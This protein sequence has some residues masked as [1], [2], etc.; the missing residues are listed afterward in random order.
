MLLLFH[1]RLYQNICELGEKMLLTDNIAEIKN[2]GEKRAKLLNSLGIYTIADLI[3]YF[4]RDYDDRSNVKSIKDVEEEQVNTIK[5]FVVSKPETLFKKNISI[6]KTRVD[7]GT[8][9]IECVWYNQPYIKNNLKP[10]SQYVFTGKVVC[11]YNR[12]QIESP[13]YELFDDSA[14]LSNG[15]I[16]PI[17]ASKAK[18]SQ[19]LL[20][21][22]IYDTLEQCRQQLIDFIPKAILRQYNLCDRAFAVENIHFPKDNESFFCAR[23]RLV[24][25]ELFL[26]QL[27]L[28][29][30]KG[31]VKAKKSSVV[32]KNLSTAPIES[33]IS[34]E[35]TSAQKRVLEEIKGDMHS[36]CVMNRLIQGDVGS[37]KTAVAMLAAYIAVNN[38][39]QAAVMAPTDVLARQHYKSFSA[40][41]E[42][43]GIKC[44]LLSAAVKAREKRIIYDSI[45][46]GNAKIIIGTHAL[47]QASVVYNRL[48]LV[49]TD[50]QHRF[51][52]NQRIKLGEKGNAPHSL[53]MTATPIPRTLALILYGDLDI[54]VIDEI[55]PGRQKIDTIAV[56]TPYRSRIYNFIKKNA[57]EGGQAYI[58]CPVIDETENTELKAVTKYAIELKNAPFVG[59]RVEYIHGKM[60]SEYKEEIMNEFAA[61]KIDVLISTT[62]IEVGINVVNASIML[63]ENAERFGLAQ[64]HQLRGRVGRGERKSYCILISDSKSSV[65]SQR[66]KAMVNSSDGFM[67]SEKDLQFRGPGDFFGTRQ[68]GVPEMKIAN[69]YKD[70]PLL[71]LAQQAAAYIYENDIRLEAQEN[72]RLKEKVEGLF[73]ELDSKISL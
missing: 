9:A 71:K 64:L 56:G 50:E 68:H 45:L 55:P 73:D 35:L 42:P 37:G 67:L 59:Y 21:S 15:R 33:V 12:M 30:I 36:G 61:G 13:D 6:T 3:E 69:L 54:S 22:L 14:L 25:E 10:K 2:V 1:K 7:D 43:L 53:V 4:P 18:L 62:V 66:L 5:G 29:Q 39:Y 17:Y 65:T 63:I 48:G 23:K 8:A 20:R 58:I 51:G 46:V 26:L 28:F 41:F 32:I 27:R 49:V 57:D 40:V 60:K 72:L 11:K 31:A 34:F 16:V 24:F 19:K 70:I 52:V 38:G 44:V 47:I